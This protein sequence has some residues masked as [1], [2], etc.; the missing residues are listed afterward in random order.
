M[1]EQLKSKVR[2]ALEEIK[3]DD[4]HES[5]HRQTM[6]KAQ[7]QLEPSDKEQAVFIKCAVCDKNFEL[8]VPPTITAKPKTKDKER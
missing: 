8:R 5:V 1:S 6:F 3:Y 7:K 2:K 4:W